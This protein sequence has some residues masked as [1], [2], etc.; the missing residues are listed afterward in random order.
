MESRTEAT[1]PQADEGITACRWTP[2]E[3]AEKLV[4]YENAR[5]V[6]RRANAMVTAE[7][8]P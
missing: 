5:A 1:Q 8:Q 2:F 6:L 3:E 7:G 4:A